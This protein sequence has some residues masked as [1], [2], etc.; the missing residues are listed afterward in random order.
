MNRNHALLCALMLSLSGH[1]F[2]AS[3]LKSEADSERVVYLVRK[4]N[5]EE[6]KPQFK[7]FAQKYGLSVATGSAFGALNGYGCSKFETYMFG[8]N[9]LLLEKFLCFMLFNSISSG[10]LKIVSEG[11]DE[12]HIKYH[13]GALYSSQWLASWIAYLIV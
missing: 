11:F 4:R 9:A 8:N 5:P 6:P 7:N 10:A 3:I 2:A 13:E 12:Y 1:A